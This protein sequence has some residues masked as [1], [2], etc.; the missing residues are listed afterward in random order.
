MRDAMWIWVK[1]CEYYTGYAITKSDEH[2]QIEEQCFSV[3]SAII[4]R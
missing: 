3:V 1:I 2:S 4:L